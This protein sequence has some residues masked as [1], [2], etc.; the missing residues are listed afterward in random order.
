M[1]PTRDSSVE[2]PCL[3]AWVLTVSLFLLM[4]GHARGAD[5]EIGPAGL[6]VDTNC[7]RTGGSC[8]ASCQCI[9]TVG[10]SQRSGEELVVTCASI[11]LP[12]DKTFSAHKMLFLPSILR[13][14]REG[15]QNL[16]AQTP[17]VLE[18]SH[19]LHPPRPSRITQPSA[20]LDLAA[21][22]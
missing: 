7:Y 22:G 4:P 11:W 14:S 9:R 10:P 16:L 17:N 12:F 1:K 6:C 15:A 18:G 2:W 13:D 5:C 21:G 3:A 20:L 19:R 8:N